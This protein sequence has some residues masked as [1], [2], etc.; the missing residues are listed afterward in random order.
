MVSVFGLP[1]VDVSAEVAISNRRRLY[2][3]PTSFTVGVLPLKWTAVNEMVG[4]R[5]RIADLYGQVEIVREV[6]ADDNPTTGIR[7]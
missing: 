6:G 2:H 5:G 3:R 4:W 1:F 7:S